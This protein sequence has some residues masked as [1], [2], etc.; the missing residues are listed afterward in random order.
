MKLSDPINGNSKKLS[1]IF[2]KIFLSKIIEL[3]KEFD[4]N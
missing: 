1:M 2:N 4:N 3:R